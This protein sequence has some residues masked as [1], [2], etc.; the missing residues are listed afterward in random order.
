MCF[1][2]QF[3]IPRSKQSDRSHFRP[4]VL[5][6]HIRF[7]GKHKKFFSRR[8]RD[9]FTQRLIFTRAFSIHHGRKA[10]PKQENERQ[11]SARHDQTSLDKTV[12]V[13]G[14][15]DVWELETRKLSFH[16]TCP[17]CDFNRNR[18][19]AHPTGNLCGFS[20]ANWESDAVNS[21]FT[22]R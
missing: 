20:A 21:Q 10:A 6:P 12:P 14:V 11:I 3:V 2:H 4:V 15:R 8:S 22:S 17:S 7:S 1:A 19:R 13:R 16:V 9:W 5:S 18:T